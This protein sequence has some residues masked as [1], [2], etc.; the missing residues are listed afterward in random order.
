MKV[1]G[2]GHALTRT[3]YI[4]YSCIKNIQLYY[5]KCNGTG[6]PLG[7]SSAVF[8]VE[9]RPSKGAIDSAMV[10]EVITRTNFSLDISWKL[11]SIVIEAE[12][13]PKN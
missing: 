11:N 7:G 3:N 1:Q 13:S 4:F 5:G 10:Q 12:H 8:K 6:K 9:R 2:Y